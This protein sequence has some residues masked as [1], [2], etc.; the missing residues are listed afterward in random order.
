MIISNAW[1]ATAE[2][3]W[4]EGPACVQGSS[5]EVDVPGFLRRMDA[6][7]YEGAVG[8]CR[9]AAAIYAWTKRLTSQ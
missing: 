2:C 3:Q 4:C 5:A 6:E 8:E 1:L 9:L 7:D